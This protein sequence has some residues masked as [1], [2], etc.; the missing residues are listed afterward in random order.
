MDLDGV[1]VTEV[2]LFHPSA[3]L[4]TF[5]IKQQEYI[6]LGPY[7]IGRPECIQDFGNRGGLC[8]I[9]GQVSLRDLAR[10]H[11]PALP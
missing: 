11:I 8:A 2:R 9:S 5:S 7:S 6:L 1:H 3:P 10:Q 4:Q